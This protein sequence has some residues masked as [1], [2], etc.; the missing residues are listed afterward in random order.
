MLVAT[1]TML[2]MRCPECGMVEYHKLS[3]FDFADGRLAQIRCSCGALKL[4]VTKK[5]ADYLVQ[6]R[7]VVCETMHM[8]TFK[9][10]LLWAPEIIALF[11]Q[12]TGVELGYIGPL[13][14]IK[15][16]T[17]SKKKEMGI[18]FNELTGEDYFHNSEVMNQVLTHILGLAEDGLV[19]CQCGNYNIGVEIFPDRLELRCAKCGAVSVVYA[20]TEEDIAPALKIKEL[21]LIQSGIMFLDGIHE[22]VRKR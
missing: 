12:D 18:L 19:S 2:A 7:C 22:Q 10:R 11:C 9:G 8:R 3:R 21:E 13:Q 20:E 17:Q 1:Q 14:K 6:V 4:A 15:G 16:L 5:E